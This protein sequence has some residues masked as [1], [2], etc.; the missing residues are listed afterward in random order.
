[1]SGAPLCA[2][3]LCTGRML[4]FALPL[5]TLWTVCYDCDLL[6]IDI[7]QHRFVLAFV[8]A[9]RYGPRYLPIVIYY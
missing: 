2:F 5:P 1:M 8:V 9:D 3:M 4:L 7:N 6:I